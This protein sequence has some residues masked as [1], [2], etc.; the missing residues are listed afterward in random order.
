MEVL[1][2]PSRCQQEI[3]I[4][5]IPWSGETSSRLWMSSKWSHLWFLHV[6]LVVFLPTWFCNSMGRNAGGIWDQG[7]N[8]VVFVEL[9]TFG[10][11]YSRVFTCPNGYIQSRA[12]QCFT[13]DFLVSQPLPPFFGP[14]ISSSEPIK[15][16]C[17]KRL[18]MTLP[19][20][21]PFF[22]WVEKLRI[23]DMHFTSGLPMRRRSVK[24]HPEIYLEQWLWLWWRVLVSMS[25]WLETKK[26]P[27]RGREKGPKTIQLQV[28]WKL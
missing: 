3:S 2:K 14:K 25:L 16:P 8:L 20:R 26:R 4:Q 21:V 28:G 27:K 22:G 1:E 5:N 11:F 19:G 18:K 24:I 9:A 17:H 7:Y 23:S 12:K 10:W 6:V 13:R 15:N